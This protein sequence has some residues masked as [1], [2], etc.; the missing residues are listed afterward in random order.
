MFVAY[1]LFVGDPGYF[2]Y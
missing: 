2:Q 1:E